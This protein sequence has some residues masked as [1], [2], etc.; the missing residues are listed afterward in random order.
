MEFWGKKLIFYSSNDC[1]CLKLKY[2][3]WKHPRNEL[4][5]KN[6]LQRAC[7]LVITLFPVYFLWNF[8]EKCIFYITN[9]R[10]GL[11]L[12]YDLRKPSRN[13]LTEKNKLQHNLFFVGLFEPE[14]VTFE[15]TVTFEFYRFQRLYWIETDLGNPMWNKLTEKNKLH[16]KLFLTIW[17]LSIFGIS[18]L[19]FHSLYGTLRKK[20]F[21]IVLTI[22]P[23]W[24]R[25]MISR[26][27]QGTE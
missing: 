19:P 2:D 15:M 5:K 3:L 1:F 21:L 20:S 27:P 17:L 6:Q 12:K 23:T 25:H 10:F 18:F 9:D 13:E 8:E 24:N 4:A 16:R 11:K 14:I 7:F 22:D 26:T